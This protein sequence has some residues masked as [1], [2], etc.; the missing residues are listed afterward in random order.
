MKFPNPT[1]EVCDALNRLRLNPDWQ[2]YL[3]WLKDIGVLQ[4]ADL[5]V[6][7]GTAMHRTQGA[8]Q[9]LEHMLGEIRNAPETYAKLKLHQLN[10]MSQQSHQERRDKTAA[11]LRNSQARR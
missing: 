9:L 6:L 4:E 10:K 8:A 2:V 1:I 7:E 11:S 3:E 5:R